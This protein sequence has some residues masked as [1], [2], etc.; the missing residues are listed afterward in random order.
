MGRR[1]PRPEPTALKLLKGN[2]GKRPLNE[3]EP[4]PSPGAPAAPAHLDEE[5][6]REWDRVIV[7]LD[8]LGL[9]TTLDRA[10]LAGYCQAW[11][12]WVDAEMKLREYGAVL[13][14][15]T[16]GVPLLSPYLT[17]ANRALEQMRQF[18]SEFGMSPAS[19]T[20]IGTDEPPAPTVPRLTANGKKADRFFPE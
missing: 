9:V 3:R 17:I 6:H 12:R 19:R 18:L 13:K 2:P 1:G 5:A 20:R 11:S 14:S 15:P 7:T 4:K 16:K 8:Q 10:A